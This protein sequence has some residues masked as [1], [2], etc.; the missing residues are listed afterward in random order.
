M[1]VMTVE[2][3]REVSMRAFCSRSVMCYPRN[4]SLYPPHCGSYLS[5]SGHIR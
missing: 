4:R 1:E 2:E 3:A 5:R